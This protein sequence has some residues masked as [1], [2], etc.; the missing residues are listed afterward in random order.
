METFD[1]GESVFLVRRILM[2]TRSQATGKEK[3]VQELFHMLPLVVFTPTSD[4]SS[5]ELIRK[6]PLHVSQSLTLFLEHLQGPRTEKIHWIRGAF[7][8]AQHT[9]PPFLADQV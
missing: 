2:Y 6:A 7:S 4:W 3:S 5:A 1:T 9:H 8:V